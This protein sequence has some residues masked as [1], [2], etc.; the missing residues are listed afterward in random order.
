VLPGDEQP[1]TSAISLRGY[2]RADLPAIFALDEI[3][4]EAPF[5]FSL[6]MMRRFAE[7]KN[8]L[9]VVAERAQEIA[10]FC[11]AHVERGRGEHVGYIVTLDVAP[12][13]RRRGLA[14]RMMHEIESQARAAGCA[15]MAL[16][17]S[18]EN[19]GAVRFYERMGYALW[20][21][22]PGFYGRGRDAIVYRRMLT[23]RDAA[24]LST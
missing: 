12:A 8:A 2:V 15:A 19:T 23:P 7:A 18:V 5:R 11:I 13:E 21:L 16:H 24:G 4:F 1:D 14:A 10:G 17:V 9:T 3:C 6:A 22:A 20:H